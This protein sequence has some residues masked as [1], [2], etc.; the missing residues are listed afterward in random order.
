MDDV[1]LEVRN[2]KEMS[3]VLILKLQLVT[4]GPGAIDIPGAQPTQS[5]SCSVMFRHI[6]VA[7]ADSHT[8]TCLL[9]A[10]YAHDIAGHALKLILAL[11]FPP[12]EDYSLST[13]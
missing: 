2:Q 13:L 11:K 10:D 1:L 7:G 12:L 9:L 5:F 8:P 6:L 4:F 3:Y